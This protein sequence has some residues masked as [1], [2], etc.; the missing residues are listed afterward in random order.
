MRRIAFGTDPFAHKSLNPPLPYYPSGGASG[1]SMVEKMAAVTNKK[2]DRAN[3]QSVDKFAE[4]RNELAEAALQTLSELGYAR[5]SLR[6]IAQNSVFSHGVLHYY[7]NDKTDLILCCVRQYKAHCVTR[8][9]QVVAESHTY[10]ELVTG[11]LKV[12]GE[13]VRNE[14]HLHR[15]WYD[16]RS[17]SLFEDAF[18]ADVLAIDKSLEDMIWRIM[19]RFSELTGLPQPLPPSVLYAVLD[20]LFQQCLLKHLSGDAAAVAE[21]QADVRL[22]LERVTKSSVVPAIANRPRARAKIAKRR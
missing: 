2:F 3:R 11:F 20:G 22:V 16:L 14:G 21:M 15:L 18:R 4:R 17:Q 6:E 1:G 10:E 12:L 13:T 5:T 19:A 7:F 9:D 8:Y